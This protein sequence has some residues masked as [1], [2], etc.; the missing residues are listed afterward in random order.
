MPVP[1]TKVTDAVVSTLSG[2]VPFSLSACESA[3]LKQDECAAAMS[4]SG[5]VTEPEP[6]ERAFQFTSKV[7][8]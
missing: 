6:S 8:A 7:P 5:V 4:S 1:G 2:G 3:M